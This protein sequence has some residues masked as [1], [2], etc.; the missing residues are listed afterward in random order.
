MTDTATGRWTSSRLVLAVTRN[1]AV[2]WIVLVAVFVLARLAAWGFP[3]DSDHWIFYYVGRNWIVE[4]G[5]LYVDAWDHKPPM[6]FLMNGIMAALLGGDI[7][8]HR[9]WLTAFAVLDAWLFHLLAKRVLPGLL[10]GVR[11]RIDPVVAVR[12]SLLLY[13]FLRNLSQFTNSGNN[14]EAYGVVLVLLLV[15]AFLKF[16]GGGAWWWLSLAGLACGVL[17]WFKGNFLIFGAAIGILLLVQGWR[18]P[19]RLI[20]HVLAY[21]APIVLVALAWFAYFAARGTFDDFWI[22]SFSFSAAYASSAWGGTV[23]S[24]IW[25]F[26]ITAALFIP[27]LVFFAL[28][29]RDARAQWR[30]PNYLLVG[31]MFLAGALLIGIVGS[32]YAFYLLIMMPFIVLVIMYGMLRLGSLGAVLRNVLILGFIATLVVNYAFSTRQLL[33]TFTG[34]AQQDAIEQRQAAEYVREHTEPGERIFANQYG[35]T[36]YQLA[37][38]RSA[39]R[40]T[41]ASWLLLDYRD[42]FGFGF[43]DIF[44]EEMEKNRAPYV[45]VGASTAELYAENTQLD[46]YFAEHFQQVEAFGDTIVLERVK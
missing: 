7:V 35:A 2:F 42:G 13:V 41:S 39:S 5:D 15:L 23:S 22:A 34:A 14:T 11:S 31:A 28:Y 19:G 12:L 8:L 21:I 44:I 26:I 27:A 29:L 33:N 16:T 45:V 24:N 36:F 9:I 4:G 1:T 20:L 18:R 43:N 40:F 37:D 10:E 32:F 38:R 30:S 6:I 3:Y 17:F 25:L 46:E